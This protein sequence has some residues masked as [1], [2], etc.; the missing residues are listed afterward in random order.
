MPWVTF[1]DKQRELQVPL[2]P[3]ADR[4][5]NTPGAASSTSNVNGSSGSGNGSANESGSRLALGLGLSNGSVDEG[6]Y[7]D[8]MMIWKNEDWA[9]LQLPTGKKDEGRSPW[10]GKNPTAAYR[11]GRKA[12]NGASVWTPRRCQAGTEAVIGLRC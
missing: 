12:I 8:A 4:P 9:Q 6:V 7:E 5:P 2:S 1:F 10:A 11:V 3:S